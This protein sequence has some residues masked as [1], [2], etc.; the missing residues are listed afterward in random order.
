[1]SE[2][3]KI[4]AEL[5]QHHLSSI[6]LKDIED[7]I[8]S[9]VEVKERDASIRTF[10]N[11]VFKNEIKKFI[12]EQL[13]F[14]GGNAGNDA[15]LQFGRGTLNGFML[16]KEWMEQ[17]ANASLPDTENEGEVIDENINIK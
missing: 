1:M 7:K 8:L 9:N 16:V 2:E 11:S 6:S 3:L 17:K 12:Q 15:Q 14:I 5:M 10:Y 4:S 13:E